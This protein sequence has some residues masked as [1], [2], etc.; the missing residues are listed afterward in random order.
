MLADGSD[1]TDTSNSFRDQGYEAA[2]PRLQERGRPSRTLISV[3]S[4]DLSLRDPRG[5]STFG[6]D[7][8]LEALLD[9][10]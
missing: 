2:H 4:G 5:A 8:V 6:A 9:N 10:S 1:K 3:A 7:S